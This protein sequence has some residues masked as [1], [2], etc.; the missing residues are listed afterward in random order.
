ML[1]S[2]LRLKEFSHLN[3]SLGVKR[4]C[5]FTDVVPGH[6]IIISPSVLQHN[7]PWCQPS[8]YSNFKHGVRKTQ[9]ANSTDPNAR[10]L[11]HAFSYR[12]YRDFN[13][14]IRNA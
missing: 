8:R 5:I 1:L 13:S 2:G 10:P 4:V 11:N 12:P 9:T 6:G 7:Q 14:S 3:D